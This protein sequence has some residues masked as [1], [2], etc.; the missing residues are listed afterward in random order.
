MHAY[1]PVQISGFTM[2]GNVYFYS[3]S[4][5]LKAIE[6]V[7]MTIAVYDWFGNKEREDKR[8]I[9][10]APQ[11]AVNLFDPISIEDFL[12]GWRGV[13]MI[14]RPLH[15]GG[16]VRAVRGGVARAVPFAEAISASEPGLRCVQVHSFGESE[17]RN[18]IH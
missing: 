16:G 14:H 1:E 4:D 2:S 15:E 9:T 13:A 6:N 18:R 8:T 11:S 5:A 10:F 17:D 3:I 12:S 7:T